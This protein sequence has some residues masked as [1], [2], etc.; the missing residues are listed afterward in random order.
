MCPTRPNGGESCAPLGKSVTAGVAHQQN[1]EVVQS[2][3][4]KAVGD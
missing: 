2:G 4:P 3:Y 1:R